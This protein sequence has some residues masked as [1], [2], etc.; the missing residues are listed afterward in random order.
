MP[1]AGHQVRDRVQA[2][3]V[4]HRRGVDDGVVD[5]D[6]VDVDEIG[7]P[8]RHQVALRQHHALG[9]TGGAAGVE[10]PGQIVR[11][12]LGRRRGAPV[13]QRREQCIGLDRLDIDLALQPGERHPAPRRCVTKAQRACASPMIH[14][15]L[16]RVQLGIHRH[17]RQ[18]GPPGAPQDFE[19]ARVVVHEEHDPVAALQAGLAQALREAGAAR[20]P[21]GMRGPGLGALQDRNPVGVVARLA[22]QQMGKAHAAGPLARAGPGWTTAATIARRPGR[23][24]S[25]APAALA[26]LAFSLTPGPLP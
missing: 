8:H 25:P 24:A 2:A 9:P 26:T 19:V 18:P 4:R 10:Q 5:V 23:R 20:G 11:S 1:R 15:S 12:A 3:A 6:R 7:Q 16:G 22:I 13:G 17:H 21:L 14:S